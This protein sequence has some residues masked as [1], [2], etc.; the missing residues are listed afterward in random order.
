APTNLGMRT[1]VVSGGG[2]AASDCEAP[3]RPDAPTPASPTAAPA[4]A[5]SVRKR[6]RVGKLFTLTRRLWCSS[7]KSKPSGDSSEWLI[8]AYRLAHFIDRICCTQQCEQGPDMFCDGRVSSV[9]QLVHVVVVS[10]ISARAV[11]PAPSADLLTPP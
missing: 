9:L 1:L 8:F 11:S 6:R 4:E 3:I 2:S 7:R 10:R 5:R